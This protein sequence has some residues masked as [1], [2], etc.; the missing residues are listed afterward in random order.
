MSNITRTVY[1]LRSVPD[2]LRYDTGVT[3]DVSARLTAHN[4][5]RCPHTSAAKPWQLDVVV[6]FSDEP[7]AV[8]FEQYL[9]SGSGVAFAKRHLR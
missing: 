5:G 3:S 6:Q 8:A 4:A 9:K 1:V 7:R 2:P